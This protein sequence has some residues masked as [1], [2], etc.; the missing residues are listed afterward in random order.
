MAVG[1]IAEARSS[2]ERAVELDEGSIEAYEWLAR[3]LALDQRFREAKEIMDR[4]LQVDPE[5][6]SLHHLY[7]QLLAQENNFGEAIRH[8]ERAIAAA[9]G[10]PRTPIPLDSLHHTLANALLASGQVERGLAHLNQALAINAGNVMV[11]NDLGLV[12]EHT[13]RLEEALKYYQR[14]TELN[15]SFTPAVENLKRIKEQMG[16]S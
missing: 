15:S 8:L 12:H 6:P 7:G 1:Q 9:S 3:T 14:A 16:I 13:G 10:D 2:F 11:L 5:A 4:G